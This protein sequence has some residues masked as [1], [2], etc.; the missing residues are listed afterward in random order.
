MHICILIGGGVLKIRGT[1][2]GVPIIR[3]I[4]VWVLHWP[5]LY[6]ND[7]VGIQM[8]RDAEGHITL[9]PEP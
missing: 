5:L 9:N 3:I 1:V 7:H 8:W 2:L 6:A 4:V